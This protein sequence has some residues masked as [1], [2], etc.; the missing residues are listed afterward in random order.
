MKKSTPLFLAL[1]FVVAGVCSSVRT[2]AQDTSLRTKLTGK[3]TNQNQAKGGATMD[4][5]SVDSAT[6]QIK[7]KYIPPSGPAGGKEF[8]VIGWVSSAPPRDKQD[9]VIVVSFS[10]SLTTY[11]SIANWTRYM[12]DSKIIAS[13]HNV[14]PNSGYDWDHITTGQDTWAKNP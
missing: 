8:D 7:G 11:G 6:G 13:W 12:K 10:V 14:R 1:C 3:W 5:T 9:N 4:I 2:V